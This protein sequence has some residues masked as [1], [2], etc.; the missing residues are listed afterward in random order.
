MPMLCRLLRIGACL[1]SLQPSG[2]MAAE[3][4]PEQM[5][6]MLASLHPDYRDYISSVRYGPTRL[7]PATLYAGL[8]RSGGLDPR[9]PDQA[10]RVGRGAT[11]VLIIYADMF[12]PWRSG[13]WRLLVADH[14]Y[15]HARHLARGF[16]IPVAGFGVSRADTAYREALAWA[17]VLERGGQGVYGPLSERELR[18]AASRYTQHYEA[19][20]EFV[21]ERQA[22]AWAH[23]GRFLPDPESLIKLASS[24]PTAATPPPAGPATR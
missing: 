10:P 12:E 21:M 3:T 23:Y 1:W 9:D 15:F 6:A 18:E 24:A 13:A 16:D 5:S 22:S 14:E 19:F 11:N 2:S 17:W 8:V 7:H 20:L 4:T